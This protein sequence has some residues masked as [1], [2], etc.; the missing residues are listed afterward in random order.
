M[1][2]ASQDLRTLFSVGMLGGL[3]DGRLL[4]QFAVHRE[5]EAFEEIVR[6]HGPMVWGVC[7]RVLRDHH[8]A[9]DA[10]QATF[11]VL[12]RKGP[13][14]AHRELVANWL[15]GVAYQ[16]AT[17]ARSTRARRRMREALV[18]DMPEPEAVSQDQRNDLT[19]WLDSELSRL[20]DKYRIPVVL[21]ELEGKTHREVAEQ[22]GWPI[23]TVSG[24]LSRARAKL[25]R[26]LSRRGMLLS[27]GSLALLLAQDAVSASMPTKLIGSTALAANLFVAA[28]AVT[29]GVVSAR[30]AILMREV[31]KMMLLGKLKVA[32]MVVLVGSAIVGGWTGVLAYRAFGSTEQDS[33]TKRPSPPEGGSGATAGPIHSWA[34][35]QAAQSRVSQKAYDQA[36]DLFQAGKVD[37]EAVHLWSQRLLESQIAA[38]TGSYVDDLKSRA[39]HVAAAEAHW[40]RM[41]HVEEVIRIL[42][43]KGRGSPLSISTAEYC[44]I[45]AEA[46][47]L[48]YRLHRDEPKSGEDLDRPKK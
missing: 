16:T 15:Y 36:L 37:L 12:A 10:F 32:T 11:L 46:L 18:T 23:G 1:K 38:A 40:D 3:S 42:V 39:I 21:C 34:G 5:E 29:A 45:R 35:F 4:E 19:E 48:E 6:R 30:V 25:A 9:E 7:R 31:M 43:E 28:G 44:R 27:A 24:R 47:V 20:P 8:D 33:Q 14:I 2:V 22:L 17:K 26:R 13:S 41:K